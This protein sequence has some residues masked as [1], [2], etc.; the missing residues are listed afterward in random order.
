MADNSPQIFLAIRSMRSTKKFFAIGV[1]AALLLPLVVFAQT[2][3]NVTNDPCKI[4]DFTKAIRLQIEI[5]G[6]TQTPG[7]PFVDGHYVKNLGCYI[8]GI[9]RYFVGVAGILATVFIMY[10]GVRYIISFGNPGS[11]QSAKETIESALVGLLI[12][13]SSYMI[14]YFINPNLTRFDLVN[15]TGIAKYEDTWCE[16]RER[17]VTPV[18]EGAV[19]CGNV[20]TEQVEEGTVASAESIK[21]FYHGTDCSDVGETCVPISGSGADQTFECRLIYGDQTLCKEKDRITTCGFLWH[22]GEADQCVGLSCG[23]NRV[24]VGVLENSKATLE[25]VQSWPILYPVDNKMYNAV[26]DDSLGCGYIRYDDSFGSVTNLKI[27]SECEDR[28]S[29]VI[30]P[31]TRYNFY[32]PSDLRPPDATIVGAFVSFDCQ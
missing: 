19:N 8:V 1:L 30:M 9:Y 21:C 10:G 14:L 26:V 2:S 28:K 3:P 27:G 25:C 5:P 4:D 6:V 31:Q 23:E 24:C 22:A 16:D 17:P 18:Q 15:V 29:C 13:I 11:L 20:G 12:A 7:V 32:G